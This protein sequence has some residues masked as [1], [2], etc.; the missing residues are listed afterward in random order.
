MH[1]PNYS[2]I[3]RIG[4]FFLFLCSIF[5]LIAF[6]CPYWTHSNFK[7]NKKFSNIGL[8]E[9]C[10]EKFKHVQDDIKFIFSGCKS[11]SSAKINSIKNFL[12]PCNS[13]N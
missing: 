8:W 10:F 11:I 13:D 12:V 3:Y 5:T 7:T 6:A 9:V 2:L 4:C 1:H